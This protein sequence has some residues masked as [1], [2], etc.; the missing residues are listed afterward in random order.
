MI[1]GGIPPYWTK[2]DRKMS[3]VSN[4][5][6][7]FFNP[8]ADMTMITSSGVILNPQKYEINSFVTLDDLFAE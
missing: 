5:D 1:M 2:F 6:R 3:L 7:L 4:I 8:Y